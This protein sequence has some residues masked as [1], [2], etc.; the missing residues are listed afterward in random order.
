MDDLGQTTSP[1]QAAVSTVR[2]QQDSAAV[3]FLRRLANREAV[4]RW[5]DLFRF[6]LDSFP[7]GRYQ[8]IEALPGGAV[9]R[10]DGTLSRWA[11][12]RPVVEELGVR[13]AVDI[14]ANE[15]F[16]S[17]RLGRLGVPTVAVESA[18][19]S[20]RTALL[21]VKRSGLDNVGILTLGVHAET[22]DLMPSADATVFLS[23]W[24]HLVKMQ[25]LA[26]ATAITT[27]LWEGT[28]RVMFFDTGEEEMDPS[29]RLPAMEPDSETWLRRYL[30]ESCPGSEI[31]HLGR[32]AAFDSFGN[33]AVRNLFAVVRAGSKP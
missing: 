26:T 15:G 25:G 29:F 13:S 1:N 20:Y 8:P 22:V 32:H 11:A 6:R 2:R 19:T 21:A 23:I 28:R 30:S 17:L 7:H 3:R 31:R 9:K 5:I 24:H 10:A 4:D 33:P 16:F 27:R 12:I 14:G 18:P